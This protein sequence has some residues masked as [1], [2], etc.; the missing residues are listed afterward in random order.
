MISAFISARN[1]IRNFFKQ[2]QTFLI[3]SLHT[4]VQ[5]E[6]QLYLDFKGSVLSLMVK[7]TAFYIANYSW[8]LSVTTISSWSEQFQWRVSSV[9][10]ATAEVQQRAHK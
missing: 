10:L 6:M 2:R 1:I 9:T 5:F 7:G 8:K 3:Y 4:Q